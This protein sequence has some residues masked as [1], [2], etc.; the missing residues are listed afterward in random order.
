MPHGLSS[1]STGMVKSVRTVGLPSV[2]TYRQLG[3]FSAQPGES[4]SLLLLHRGEI[5]AVDPDQVDRAALVL[6]GRLLGD[7]LGHGAR[8]VVELHMDELDAVAPLQL[9]ARPFDIGVDVFRAA[10]G[11]PVDR[12][13]L[14]L[15][16]HGIPFGRTPAHPEGLVQGLL[17][18][19]VGLLD[20]PVLLRLPGPRWSPAPGRS[21]PTGPRSAASSRGAPPRRAARTAAV[22]WSVWWW[23]GRPPGATGRARAPPPGPRSSP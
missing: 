17:E 2:S 7:H 1:P 13:A 18:A 9:G 11:V 8:G 21:G 6:A 12:L 3:S 15:G 20:V 5:L 16:K 4:S 14:G 10:P 19:E 22:S 23:R